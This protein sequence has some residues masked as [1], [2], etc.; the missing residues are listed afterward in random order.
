VLSAGLVFD[1]ARRIRATRRGRYAPS[2]FR[3][4]LPSD[5]LRPERAAYHAHRD[6]DRDALAFADRMRW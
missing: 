4:L 6:A 3:F 2:L 5:P 1:A